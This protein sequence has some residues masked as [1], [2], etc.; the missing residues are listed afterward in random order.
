MD[1]TSVV[2]PIGSTLVGAYASYLGTSSAQKKALAAARQARVDANQDAGVAAL[3]ES[4]TAILRHV[5]TMPRLSIGEHQSTALNVAWKDGQ[6][7]ERW[8]ETLQDLVGSARMAAHTLRDERVRLTLLEVFDLLEEWENLDD[9]YHAHYGPQVV[10][11]AVADQGVLCL[12]AFQREEQLPAPTK[13][14][15]DTKAVYDNV[16]LL[17]QAHCDEEEAAQAAASGSFRR[18]ARAAA[19]ETES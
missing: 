1:W 15:R 4:F 6:E 19:A 11:R 5:R 3:S 9:A 14:Y 12:A 18:R 2:I 17:L 16:F 7:K 13:V 8:S 10:L